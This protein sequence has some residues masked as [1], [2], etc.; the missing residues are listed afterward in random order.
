MT[1]PD[2]ATMLAFITTDLEVDAERCQAALGEAVEKT[3]NRISIDGCE[4]TNDSVF[5]LASG[6][7]GPAGAGFEPALQ[8]V[9]ASLAEQ[10][11]RDA[12]GGSRFVRVRVEGASSEEHAATLGRA[13][14]ASTLWRAAMNGGDPNWG[15]VLAAL[16]AADRLLDPAGVELAIGS[17]VVFQNG[18][19]AGS[20]EVAAKVM[21]EPE[22]EVR[23]KVGRG[24]GVAEVLTADLSCEYVRLNAE[25]TS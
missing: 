7:A 10:I 8:R 16:G 22:Y 2:M 6:T 24:A 14:A 17:E 18:E 9:C 20:R 11:V 23:C 21:A 15:R 13:V 1:A 5:L 4:S 3:F 25:G 12:E 19:P